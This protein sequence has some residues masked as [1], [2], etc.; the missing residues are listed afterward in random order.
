MS[1]GTSVRAG[2]K[3]GPTKKNGKWYLCVNK[4]R[5]SGCPKHKAQWQIPH[6]LE[7]EIFDTSDEENWYDPNSGHYYGVHNYGETILGSKG[8]RVCKFPCPRNPLDPWHGYPFKKPKKESSKSWIPTN[9]L[10]NWLA[11]G[12]ID[13]SFYHRI[14]KGKIQ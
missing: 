14:L 2:V 13:T 8:E 9:V 6:T 4:H 10:D 7:Y 3:F 11:T 5:G 1:S 12:A